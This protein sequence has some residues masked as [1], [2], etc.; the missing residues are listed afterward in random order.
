MG[1]RTGNSFYAKT[2]LWRRL[3]LSLVIAA[4]T[5]LWMLVLGFVGGWFV[6]SEPNME[7]VVFFSGLCAAIGAFAFVASIVLFEFWWKRHPPWW[8]TMLDDDDDSIHEPE[9]RG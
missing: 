1:T 4:G 2:P 3:A 5:P 6:D 9:Y 7:S 8:M